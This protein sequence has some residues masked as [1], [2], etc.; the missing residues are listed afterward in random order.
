ML[1]CSIALYQ[2]NPVRKLL[3][4]AGISLTIYIEHLSVL[5]KII[6]SNMLYVDYKVCVILPYYHQFHYYCCSM[7]YYTNLTMLL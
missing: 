3:E 2:I 5:I 6:T 1:Q 4:T 7:R